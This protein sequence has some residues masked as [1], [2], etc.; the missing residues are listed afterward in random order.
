MPF[1]AGVAGNNSF[2]RAIRHSPTNVAILLDGYTFTNYDA[3]MVGICRHQCRHQRHPGRRIPDGL[4]HNMG[5]VFKT[6]MLTIDSPFLPGGAG[7][8]NDQ[9][10]EAIPQAVAGLLK[11]G[12]PRFVIYAFGQALKP[13]DIY[14]GQSPISTSAP[15][16]RS[17]ASLSSAPFAMSSATP[18]PPA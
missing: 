10:V 14:F 7:A 11:L 4:F 5:S 18:P 15:T 9:Q 1:S 16:T 6:P 13:K 8:Y 17:P 2:L 3:N 12:Q